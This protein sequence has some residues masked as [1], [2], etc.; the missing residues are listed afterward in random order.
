[1]TTDN[2]QENPF[3][4][5]DIQGLRALA[6]V[7]VV[8]FHARLPF[9][10]G[11]Y[12]GVDVF[13][14][15][16]GY[17]I[18]SLLMRELERCG[19]ID[20]AAFYARRIRR[21]LPAAM[22]VFIATVAMAR[23]WL[24]PLEQRE[25]APSILY[26]ALY[27]SNL[28]FASEATDYL[29][30]DVHTNPL[31]HTWSLA[32][33]EQFYLVWP[34]LVLLGVQWGSAV[35]R[36][37]RLGVTMALVLVASLTASLWVMEIS[38]PWAF[39][40]SPTR[41]WEFA[42]GG[43]A[44]MVSCRF[45]RLPILAKD[46][47]ATIGFGAMVGAVT[48]FDEQ[49]RFPGLMA[50]VPVVGAGLMLAVG[51]GQGRIGHWFDHPVIQTTGNLSYSWYLWHWPILVFAE[52]VATPPSL[53]TRLGYVLL[54]FVLA[55]LT[56]TMVENR[57]RFSP[58]LARS[59]LRSLILGVTLTCIGTGSALILSVVAKRS[60]AA[61]VQA[62]L[63]SARE[64]L[65]KV[66]ADGCH[67]PHLVKDSPNCVYGN[68]SARKTWVLFGDSHA[69]QWFPALER[70]A[71]EQGWRL[72]SL[73]KSACPSVWITPYNTTLGRSYTECAR[74]RSAAVQRIAAEHPDLIILADYSAYYL[75]GPQ[76]TRAD[77]WRE[78]MRRTLTEL[79]P[80]GALILIFHDIPQ[81]GFD[82]PICLSRASWRNIDIISACGFRRE[83]S[84]RADILELERTAVGGIEGAEVLDLYD[85]I[86]SGT[87]CPPIIG[88]HVA[89]R[90][91]NHLTAGASASLA[92]TL[93][94]RLKRN[95]NLNRGS[96]PLTDFSNFPMIFQV[97]DPQF[98]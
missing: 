12:V 34:L 71:R 91:S 41:A 10:T 46:L 66:Y 94:L 84:P 55:G 30:V 68:P 17:L 53:L 64:D 25:L 43:L 38:Q 67:L 8:L 88:E 44:C 70:I 42:A 72:I 77:Q 83:E 23:T 6:V 47:L 39:F 2:R 98:Q 85:L 36:R 9:F 79:G 35:Q 54:S 7:F 69:A 11:G 5:S 74:W 21:L 97:T 16:S 22:T 56:Y 49:T 3:F 80:S 63:I 59:S 37:V 73:T 27:A 33:E 96:S 65:P 95:Q 61:P 40:G 57:V 76:A 51:G 93:L 31:L 82:M 86:C 48:L 29:A 75:S 90:D 19:R 26:S 81:P 32:V 18:T 20:F 1:M 28:W 4:R 62:R 14:V 45:E 13:F 58:V 92:P 78:G 89:Y 52:A 60:L 50:L 87:I 15:I 24:S